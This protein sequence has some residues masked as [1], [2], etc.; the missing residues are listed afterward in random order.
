MNELMAEMSRADE[1]ALDVFQ[2]LSEASLIPNRGLIG[3]KPLSF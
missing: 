3:L 2:G 1:A